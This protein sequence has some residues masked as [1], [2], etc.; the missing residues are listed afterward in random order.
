MTVGEWLESRNMILK[1]NEAVNML[2]EVSSAM[3]SKCSRIGEVVREMSWN[4]IYAQSEEQFQD[5]WKQMQSRSQMLGIDIV[6]EYYQSIW[7]VALM[8][9]NIWRKQINGNMKFILADQPDT[10]MTDF[11]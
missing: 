7:K 9:K 11:P 8:K 3:R 6:S 5:L 2:P 4:M 1:E 10:G